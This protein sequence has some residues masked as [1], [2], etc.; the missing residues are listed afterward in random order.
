MHENYSFKSKIVFPW[1]HLS[2]DIV[3][4]QIMGGYLF[5]EN[6]E[7]ME[8]RKQVLDIFQDR[9]L[10]KFRDY[11]LLHNMEVNVKHLIV[12]M[13]DNGLINNLTIQRQAIINEFDYW[14]PRLEY[15]KTRTV[16]V[17]S[18]KLN[19]TDRTIWTALKHHERKEKSASLQ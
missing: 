2:V 16:Q 13:I 11:C 19:L 1:Q 9:L 8:N 12:Y 15:H 10:E 4:S 6:F 3:D 7:K 17:I 14:F 5:I 18:N